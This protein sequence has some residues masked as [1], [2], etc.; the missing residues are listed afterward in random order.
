[1][2]QADS[3]VALELLNE[4]SLLQMEYKIREQLLDD[5]IMKRYSDEKLI[6]QRGRYL[7]IDL[8]RKYCLFVIDADSFEGKLKDMGVFSEEKVQK[9]KVQ[10]RQIISDE[11]MAFRL[12]SLILDSSVGCVGLICLRKESDIMECKKVINSILLQLKQIP[13]G[14]DFSAGIG[15]VKQGIRY[16][17]DGRWEA[18]LAMRAGR[19]MNHS[20]K[21]CA[22]TF[23]ELGCL[24][25]LSEL[26]NSKAMRAFYNDNLQPL[27]DYD[28][29]NGTELEK[30]LECYFMNGKNLRKTAEA[31]FMHKN[32]IIYRISKIES[33]LSKNMDDY[34]AAFD[35]Q[36]C[37]KLKNIM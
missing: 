18:M 13:G 19:N 35:L 26:A 15:R 5:L 33:L 2:E 4:R 32:S 6:I 21:K 25:F 31:L 10:V 30:T 1:L 16:I 11:M 29:A 14:P 9:I 20:S 3:V 37:F 36:L 17:E 27:I 7:G 34:H 28:N 12:P 22:H 23:E 8:E 24:C